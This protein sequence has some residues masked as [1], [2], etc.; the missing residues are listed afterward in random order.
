MSNSQ[1]GISNFQGASS[2]AEEATADRWV[3]ASFF[4]REKRRKAAKGSLGLVGLGFE[5]NASR[6]AAEAQRGGE[7][8]IS[9]EVSAG[10]I[11]L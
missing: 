9:L 3:E 2:Y 7:V 10:V 8:M 1:Q 6:R 4:D 5:F 11:A